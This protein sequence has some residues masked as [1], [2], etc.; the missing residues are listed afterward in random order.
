M[1]ALNIWERQIP[2][3]AVYA[4]CVEWVCKKYGLARSE[5]DILMFLANNPEY[6]TAAD[7]VEIKHM[8]K[9]HVSTSVQN[10]EKNG[11]I[12]KY[13]SP[14]NQKTI[15]L[16]LCERSKEVISD[17]KKALEAFGEILFGGMTKEETAEF[18]HLVERMQKNMREYLEV[19]K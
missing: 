1:F 4:D 2:V 8:T 9:S 6:N 13:R 11:Y 7:I 17:G 19:K 16:S 5:L 12:T 14:G 15:H 10:L 18:W 3:K